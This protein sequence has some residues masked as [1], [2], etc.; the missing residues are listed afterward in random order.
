MDV[1]STERPRLPVRPMSDAR[2]EAV[3]N[4]LGVDD[5]MRQVGTDDPHDESM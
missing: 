3:K 5:E 4:L 1:V 2:F